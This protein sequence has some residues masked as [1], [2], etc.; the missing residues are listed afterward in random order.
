MAGAQTSSDPEA[1]AAINKIR[2]RAGLGNLNR[3]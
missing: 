1:L 2:N 3:Y